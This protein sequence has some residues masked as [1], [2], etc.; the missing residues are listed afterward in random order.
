[1]NKMNENN[2]NLHKT[3]KLVLSLI[4][5]TLLLPNDKDMKDVIDSWNKD[6]GHSLYITFDK[7]EGL[8]ID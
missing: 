6:Y 5:I 3:V 2:V 7:K 4:M 1:M 8:K